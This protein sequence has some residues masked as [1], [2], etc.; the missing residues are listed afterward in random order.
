MR[1]KEFSIEEVKK[2][3][4][5]AVMDM[6]HYRKHGQWHTGSAA[7]LFVFTAAEFFP[8]GY[9]SK[10]TD[11]P[12][13]QLSE[14]HRKMMRMLAEENKAVIFAVPP[15]YRKYP[16]VVDTVMFMARLGALHHIQCYDA[17]F[18]YED[19]ELDYW[20][21]FFFAGG[22]K[23][24]DANHNDKVRQRLA[25]YFVN[26]TNFLLRHQYGHE[27]YDRFCAMDPVAMK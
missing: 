20:G 27:D 18:L 10:P 25:Q 8:N 2:Y 9:N 21:N 1:G 11:R 15:N 22:T 24:T 16:I 12:L 5:P 3:H 14:H 13:G 6:Q 26:V 4:N 17:G 19:M 7:Y 23:Y